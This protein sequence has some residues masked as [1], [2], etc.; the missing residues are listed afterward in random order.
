[1]GLAC[2]EPSQ[3]G[4][5]RGVHVAQRAVSLVHGSL[6]SRNR[7]SSEGAIPGSLL[8]QNCAMLRHAPANASRRGQHG[9]TAHGRCILG[10]YPGRSLAE[11][12][13]VGVPIGM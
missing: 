12:V 7:R 11:T 6:D 4:S 2:A 10:R 9:L 8:P 3:R 1:M 5:L 13:G